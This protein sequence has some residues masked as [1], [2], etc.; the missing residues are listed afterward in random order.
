[1]KNNL[2]FLL[3]PTQPAIL[4]LR[5][6]RN[7]QLD[8]ADLNRVG[9]PFLPTLITYVCLLQYLSSHAVNVSL[10]VFVPRWQEK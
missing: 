10:V 9:F 8:Y 7:H 1:M 3:S 4:L 5:S 2:H 6:A